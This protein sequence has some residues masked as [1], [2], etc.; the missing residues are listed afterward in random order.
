MKKRRAK[1]KTKKVKKIP[2]EFKSECCKKECGEKKAKV[3]YLNHGDAHC[4][5]LFKE[6]RGV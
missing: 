4:T 3:C 1:P 5:I 2:F 6:L